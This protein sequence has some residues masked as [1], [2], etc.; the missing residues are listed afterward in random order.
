MGGCDR[1]TMSQTLNKTLMGTSSALHVLSECA[2]WSPGSVFIIATIVTLVSL[3]SI[4]LSCLN[5]SVSANRRHSAHLSVYL[6]DR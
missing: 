6:F 4:H 1:G 3:L 2:L 5:C